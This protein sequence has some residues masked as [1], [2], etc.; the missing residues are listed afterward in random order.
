MFTMIHLFPK[1]MYPSYFPTSFQ[2]HQLSWENPNHSFPLI[3]SIGWTSVQKSKNCSFKDPS[4]DRKEMIEAVAKTDLT[5][6][7][8]LAGPPRLRQ[9]LRVPFLSFLS[10]FITVRSSRLCMHMGTGANFI[11]CIYYYL[12]PHE[13]DTGCQIKMHFI[14]RA[15]K[16][17]QFSALSLLTLTP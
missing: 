6:A 4:N 3:L 14:I 2:V 7:P 9:V 5:S 1:P 8:G 16:A 12:F 10:F 15:V 17:M 11:I 13:N